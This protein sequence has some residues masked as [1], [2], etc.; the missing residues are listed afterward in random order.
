MRYYSIIITDPKSG[1]VLTPTSLKA[2][3]VTGQT[4]TSYVNGQTLPGA[5]NVELNV[6]VTSFGTPLGAG[7]VRVWGI[8]I[9]EISQAND[10]AGKN[11]Q[12]FA[13]MQ[14]GLPLAKPAQAGLI[15]NGMISQSFGNWVGTAQTLDLIVTAGLGTVA[16]P[17]NYVH[18]WLKGTKLADAITA[19]LTAAFPDYTVDVK[20][21]D[22]LV[23][24][25]TDVGFY[26]TPEEYAAYV[27]QLSTSIIGGTYQGV[28]ITL[29]EKTFVVRDGT[30][31]T[32]P[33]QILFEDLIGQPT[34]ID[35]LTLQFKTAIRADI[36]IQDYVKMPPTVVT[37]TAGG[38]QPFGSTI[39]NNS[40]FQ[41]TFQVTQLTHFGNL[42]QPDAESWNTTFNAVGNPT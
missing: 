42:R 33:L 28:K 27:E 20:I 37:T 24:T 22:E 31:P 16:D 1:Q 29:R 36:A 4:Y 10:L 30:A 38:A 35:P 11:I 2:A 23:L 21:S 3:G 17:K 5:L 7:Y 19:T 6:P 40:I 26:G 41:G 12:V 25:E 32:S 14:K 13:G 15:L 18:H 34:W 8:S 9:Q 39:N